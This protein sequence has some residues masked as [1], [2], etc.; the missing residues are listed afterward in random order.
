M[1]GVFRDLILVLGNSIFYL[2]E[3]DY[4]AYFKGDSSHE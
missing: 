4:M 2:P 1:D 3:G